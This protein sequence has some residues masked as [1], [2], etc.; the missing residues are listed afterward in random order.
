M[1]PT[2][3]LLAGPLVLLASCV[4]GPVYYEP[5]RA[6]PWTFQSGQ[7]L[8]V[9]AGIA[10]HDSI[11]F[12]TELTRQLAETSTFIV[13]SQ[14]EVTAAF[15][16]Y[17]ATILDDRLS[18]ADSDIPKFQNIQMR[19]GTDYILVAWCPIKE[20]Y[21]AN[22]LD[23]RFAIGFLCQM[24]GFPGGRKLGWSSF[25]ESITPSLTGLQPQDQSNVIVAGA[26]KMASA[27][28]D[29]TDMRK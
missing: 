21:S 20:M 5:D 26:E 10:D 19:L 4:S 3:F 2:V 27:L 24:L 7:S 9:I 16:E 1:K 13:K 22:N 12:A 11:R 6:E 18:L 15:P 17:P 29:K 8:V 28:V 23:S 14:S 25:Y